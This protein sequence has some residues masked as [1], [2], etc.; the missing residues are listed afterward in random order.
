MNDLVSPVQF[1]TPEDAQKAK[2][3]IERFVLEEQERCAKIIE[4]HV[5]DFG[6]NWVMCIT[7]EI[8]GH[9]GTPQLQRVNSKSNLSEFSGDQSMALFH[10]KS[11][12]L[13]PPMADLSYE[14]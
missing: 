10:T 2:T 4:G 7:K 8:R 11:K 3:L 9:W 5:D 6:A 13:H 12:Q 14:K 1:S